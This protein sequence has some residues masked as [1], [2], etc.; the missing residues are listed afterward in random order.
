MSV[1]RSLVCAAIALVVALP[2]AARAQGTYKTICNDGKTVNASGQN[3]CDMHGGIH[4][5]RTTV[6]HRSP[7]AKR[8][9]EPARV[10]QAGTPAP[11]AKPNYEERRGWRWHH[12]HEEE[13]HAKHHRVRCRD[14]RSE[15]ADGKGKEVC[16][17]HGGLAH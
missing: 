15:S 2:A 8:Q 14:G 1:T 9:G 7:S 6:L 5:V 13:K 10:A 11:G 12:R 16:K 17:H 4:K 3:A